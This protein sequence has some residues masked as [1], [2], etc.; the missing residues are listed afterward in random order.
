MLHVQVIIMEKIQHIKNVFSV[1]INAKNVQFQLQTALG[2]QFAFYT[3]NLF[4][5]KETRPSLVN[6]TDCLCIDRY[7]SDNVSTNHC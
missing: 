1:I 5:C 3:I 6:S 7:Y 4:S 2:I